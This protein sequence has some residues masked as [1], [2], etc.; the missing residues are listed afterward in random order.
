M[1]K[2]KFAAVI[3]TAVFCL[4]VVQCRAQ[5][6]LPP[7]D[8]PIEHFESHGE[9]ALASIL[10]LGIAGKVPLGIV[11]I[12]DRLCKNKVDVAVNNEPVLT[13]ANRLLKGIDGYQAVVRDGIMVIEPRAV[14]PTSEQILNLVIERYV[15][16]RSS[17]QE[18]G[19]YL[20]RYIY[21]VFHPTEG[22]MM[23][24]ISGETVQ[25]TPF[26]M[27][28]ATVEQ[29]LNRIVKEGGGGVWVMPPIPDDY[30]DK[31]GLKL[32]DVSSYTDDLGKIQ[33]ISCTP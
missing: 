16:P 10:K 12:D 1:A 11:Q 26:E 33:N 4:F 32:A 17:M 22:T 8:R 6:K 3:G 13:A 2:A 20:W 27:H 19:L 28:G 9:P 25:I 24:M 18:L 21:A 5:D 29:I 14:P 31:H 7:Y 15:A 23:E 30:R